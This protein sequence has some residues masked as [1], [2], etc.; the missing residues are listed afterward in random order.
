MRLKKF[1]ILFAASLLLAAVLALCF[2]PLLVAGGLR[3][4]A[5]HLARE[6]GLTI[7]LGK[8]EAQLLRPVVV[9]KVRIK[10][11]PAA[12]FRVS[13]EV[14]RLELGLNFSAIF[15]PGRG[16]FLHALAAEGI[17]ADIRRNAQTAS[18][19]PRFAW[20]VVEDLLADNFK[21]SGLQLHV[22]DPSTSVD[23]H[24]ATLSGAQMEAGLFT[25]REFTIASPWLHK[26]FSDL[27]GATSWQEDRFTLGAVVL[28]RGLDLDTISIDL[29]HIS[30]SRIDLEMTLDAFGGKLRARVSSDDRGD[31]R[32]WDAA[33]SATE[34]SLAQM[35][36]ALDF[37][38]RASGSLHASRFTFRGEVT[39]LR[40]A[41]ATVWAEVTGLTW[42]DRTADT[43]MIGASLYNREVQIEQLYVKQRNN[44]LT[45][46]G[47]FALPRQ[48][49]DL[50][51][52]DFRGDISASINDLGEFAR[53]FGASPSG[54]AGS[55]TMNGS[56]SAHERKLGGSLA[57]S[58]Q[59]LVLFRAPVESLTAKLSLKESKLEIEEFEL[60]RK[61]DSFRGQAG[62]DLAGER[63][64]SISFKGSIGDLAEYAGLIPDALRRFELGGR[65]EL[66]WNAS[67]TSAAHSG[68]F[69]AQGHGLHLLRS[70]VTPFDV[71]LEGDYSPGNIFF[72]Q[73]HL[74]NPHL[75]FSAFVTIAKDYFQLQTLRLDLNGKPKLQGNVF[76]PVTLSK[77]IAQDNWLSALSGDPNFDLDVT[78][79]PIDLAELAAAVTTR[80]DMSGQ[81]AGRIEVYGTPASLEGRSD[82][83]LRDFVFQNE[84]RLTADLEARLTGGTLK[85]KTNVT[86]SGSDPLA[87]EASIPFQPEKTETGYLLKTDG[88]LSATLNFPAIFL[89]R[90]PRYVPRGIFQGGILSGQL[91]ISDSLG[92][93]RIL[94]E[95][96]L[97]DGKFGIGAS[98]STRVMFAGQS[99]TI[100]FAQISQDR[101]LLTGR[102]EI[103]FHELDQI[104]LTIFPGAPLR[105]STPLE[106]G[107]C[108]S[109]LEFSAM[110]LNAFGSRPVDQIDFRGSLSSTNWTISLRQDR[111]ADLRESPA[112]SPRTFPFCWDDRSHGKTLTL[113]ASPVSF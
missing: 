19:S 60:K 108:V 61:N 83:H 105:D 64:Y 76:V 79:D 97:I 40:E 102:G 77:I 90:V 7:E 16:R 44:Q 50:L 71:D 53:L 14:Q 6:S 51:N 68:I 92:Q 81:A 3:L 39:N 1:L 66:D 55:V 2:A 73:F 5:G 22:E 91:A 43:V 42:R 47:E 13:I 8:I 49:A 37:T 72:R 15:S 36:D 75:D 58:G 101:A 45:L 88:P 113:R 54:F 85:V 48:W 29:S 110:A 95:L 93:P 28:T 111:S 70:P 26:T 89:A 63:P 18:G 52:P 31:R 20:R 9:E 99:A 38:D 84:T 80:P 96:H 67:G 4:W 59:A 30:E 65:L 17:S 86:A 98:L 56:V 46:N 12:P 35:S 109:G 41:T 69:H 112:G 104:A 107:D 87:L 82:V 32:I 106:P 62:I 27:R 21:F 100:E 103:D 33:G 23:L 94:G 11:G 78:L 24:D 34:I 25:A 10:T 57:V 74:S